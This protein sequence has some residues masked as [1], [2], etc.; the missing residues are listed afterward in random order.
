MATLN[1][2]LSESLNVLKTYQDAHG[3]DLVIHGVNTLGEIHTKRLVNAGY[4]MPVIKGWFI[5]SSPGASGDSTVWYISYW[6]FVARYL[7]SRFGDNWSL[8]AELS[9]Y[10]YSGK[11]VVPKQLIV[12]SGKGSNNILNLPFDTSILDIKATVPEYVEKESRYGLRLYSLEAALINVLPEYYKRNPIEVKTCLSMI[13]S[14]DKLLSIALD[15]GN[16]TKIGKVAG[17]LRAIGRGNLADEIVSTMKS[18][19]YDTREV[20][21]FDGNDQPMA[22]QY[23]SPY[24]SR[25][26]LMWREM[27]NRVLAVEP[28]PTLSLDQERVVE[29]IDS[30]YVLDSYNSLSIEGYKVT[31]GL[32]ERVRSGKWA[33]DGEDEERKNALAARGYYQAY[34]L[35]KGDIISILNGASAGET[36]IK[37]HREWHFQLFEPCIRAG[38]IKASDLIGYRRHQVYIRNSMHTPLNPDAIVDAMSVLNDLMS[39]ETNPFV[40]AVLG[41]FFFVYIH[42]FMDGNGRTARFVMNTQLVTGG[43]KWVIVPVAERDSYM[44]ALEKASVESDIAPFANFIAKLLQ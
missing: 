26:D 40:R 35:V 36:Y 27:R 17:G 37:K 34:Q 2:K 18:V 13:R 19:G 24:A 20:N 28:A 39:S 41:H 31:E 11:S 8:S 5:P 7:E 10:F 32:I 43:Y 9:L 44:A 42:P 21:P 38:I 12:R 4:L 15:N 23:Y 22:V 6:P 30:S 16:S 29:M 33:P 1:E 14:I 3:D 25:I